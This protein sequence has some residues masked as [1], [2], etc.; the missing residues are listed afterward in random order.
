MI[1]FLF[2]AFA[3]LALAGGL[4]SVTRRE[5]VHSALWLVVTLFAIAVL[6]LL[7]SAEFLFAVQIFIYAGGIMVL[8]LFVIFLVETQH[9]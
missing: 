1:N 4:L 3:F 2:Y 6:Y 8:Y 9:P 7:M 5:P